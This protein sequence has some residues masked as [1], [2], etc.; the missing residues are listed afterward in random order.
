M[1]T[2][3]KLFRAAA[4]LAAALSLS[5]CAGNSASAR[6]TS[7]PTPPGAS[8]LPDESAQVEAVQGEDPRNYFIANQRALNAVDA[9]SDGVWDDVQARLQA[10]PTVAGVD[11]R[12]LRQMAVAYQQRLLYTTRAQARVSPSPTARASACVMYRA[13]ASGLNEGQALRLLNAA[14]LAVQRAL[15]VSKARLLAN[16]Y[17]SALSSGGGFAP[18]PEAEGSCQ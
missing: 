17:S 6:A 13:T 11:P 8:Q 14:E 18:A 1:T 9:D 2:P 7:N 12:A 15:Y 5:A 16:E 10:D 4:L 3:P